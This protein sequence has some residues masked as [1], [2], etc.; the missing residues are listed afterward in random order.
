MVVVACIFVPTKKKKKFDS[1]AYFPS[2]RTGK[3]QLDGQM[4]YET[5]G[6]YT[7]DEALETVGFGRFQAFVLGYAGLGWFAEAMEIMILSFIGQA[8]K[9]EW[10]LSSTQESL[11]STI[12]FAGMLIGAYTW[13]ILSDN[14]GRRK[15]FLFISMV[16]FGAGFLSTFSPNYLSLVVLRGLV[17]FG[18][19]GSSVFLSWF[20][21]FVPA[22]NRGMWMVVF[23]TFWTFG[24]IFEATLAWIVMPRLDWRWVLAFSSVPSFALLLLFSVA[25]ESPRY[26]CMKGKTSDALQVLEKVA[27]V[28]Q[29]KLPPG[30]LISSSSRDKDEESAPS[31]SEETSPLLTSLSENTKQSISGFSSFFML[32][33]SKLIKTTMLLWVLFFGDSFSYY[34]IILLTSKL[35]SN[36]SGCFQSLHSTRNLHGADLYENAFITSMAELP[37]LFL[38]AILVDRVGRKQ[39][40]A[41]MFGLAFIFLLPLLTH[42]P[43]VLTT[44]L[45]FGARMNAMGTFT[46]AS[47]YSPELYPTSVRTTGAGVASAIGR[48]GGMVCPLVAVGL[49]N[50][51]HQTAAVAL[52]LVAIVVSIVCIQFF[53]YDTKGREL[54]DT[55]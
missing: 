15:G 8:V 9:T 13:G 52:F 53:P 48:I 36:Q 20:L 17:G 21:E 41:F 26:L 37:G 28:N 29:T 10:Q 23:S 22:S 14:Y 7:L 4:D 38:S 39:S 2:I 16:T 30:V 40:M 18:L 5:A 42:Q 3:Q 25:P 35:S 49:V 54:S 32:F 50:S 55:N 33:S 19:G 12:V 46:V 6:L 51:C 45:L 43:S 34:G 1:E 47:I 24:S 44:C 31:P 11:L 27:S